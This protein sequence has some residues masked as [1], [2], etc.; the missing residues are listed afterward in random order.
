MTGITIW[1]WH[2]I[3]KRKGRSSYSPLRAR[4]NA[5]SSLNHFCNML[6]AFKIKMNISALIFWRIF[7]MKKNPWNLDKKYFVR[8]TAAKW[9]PFQIRADKQDKLSYHLTKYE[10]NKLSKRVGQIFTYCHLRPN[11]TYMALQ[12]WQILFHPLFLDVE[13]EILSKTA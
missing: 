8:K 3:N 6:L 2:S 10:Q 13:F 11:L 7:I 1:I 9:P 12:F 4:S 5:S